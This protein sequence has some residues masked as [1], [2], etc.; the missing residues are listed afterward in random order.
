MANQCQLS[1]TRRL[2]FRR[3]SR[4]HGAEKGVGPSLLNSAC[5]PSSP[6]T[7]HR[8]AL[9]NRKNRASNN[10][11]GPFDREL[12]PAECETIHPVLLHA[13]PFRHADATTTVDRR[14]LVLDDRTN[15]A[16]HHHAMRRRRAGTI[17]S[18]FPDEGESRLRCRLDGS[19]GRPQGR[20]REHAYHARHAST[21]RH[22][23][24]QHVRNAVCI[25]I[26]KLGGQDRSVP[27]IED[28]EGALRGKQT[29]HPNLCRQDA[30]VVLR[31]DLKSFRLGMSFADQVLADLR[32]GEQIPT[33][34]IE[35]RG[36]N[37]IVRGGAG[38]GLLHPA[39]GS[40]RGDIPAHCRP[41]L[42]HRRKIVRLVEKAFVDAPHQGVAEQGRHA[43][44]GQ[45]G[46]LSI[47]QIRSPRPILAL[48]RLH[49][50]AHLAVEIN[51]KRPRL[52]MRGELTDDEREPAKNP[53][54]A[55]PP[56]NVQAVCGP[57]L[58]D[59]K[60]PVEEI[61]FTVVEAGDR[62]AVFTD[63]K[64][65]ITVLARQ[66]GKLRP[67]RR[68]HE[69]RIA[70]GPAQGIRAETSIGG[71]LDH[72]RPRTILQHVVENS[73][74]TR[75]GRRGVV[76]PSQLK[77]GLANAVRL[78]EE[79]PP[80]V[81][82]PRI[83]PPL[84][85]KRLQVGQIRMRQSKGHEPRIEH[86]I[87]PVPVVGERGVPQRELRHAYTVRSDDV[88]LPGIG[89]RNGNAPQEKQGPCADKDAA[90]HSAG[91][92]LGSADSH[93]TRD[94]TRRRVRP[95][96]KSGRRTRPKSAE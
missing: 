20:I 84:L 91:S 29:L 80:T 40:V 90:T 24:E 33:D 67:D 35:R 68:R 72:R 53:A 37:A 87:R 88:K 5:H 13:A 61:V 42:L 4:A 14:K 92:R 43:H 15:R 48:E 81:K 73:A 46:I 70:P 71:A 34:G 28:N 1:C 39:K 17:R 18:P 93:A 63:Q 62:R 2:D 56:E 31:A 96:S 69:K 78:G 50:C 60:V 74:R 66:R 51:E 59:G 49:L 47:Q 30:E 6:G 94:R 3:S 26:P 86:T 25:L 12:R 41:G 27:F 36:I 23:E 38:G 76:V 79:R 16:L 54:I 57:L 7:G 83:V 22:A 55:P 44:L 58:A 65:P 11:L 9:S 89:S 21:Q 10:L 75:E 95:R 77:P 52:Q 45:I 19:I 8:L 85:P 64:V 32:C 82:T